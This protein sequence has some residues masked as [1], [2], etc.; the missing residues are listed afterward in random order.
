MK[1]IRILVLMIVFMACFGA[2][3][4]AFAA[5][6]CQ[7]VHS[8]VQHLYIEKSPLRDRI[9]SALRFQSPYR[10]SYIR[11][12]P[13]LQIKDDHML[14]LFASFRENRVSQAQQVDILL[15]HPEM[16]QMKVSKSM[17]KEFVRSYQ[18][19]LQN[20][21]FTEANRPLIQNKMT[22][23]VTDQCES[24]SCW[25]QSS[26]SLLSQLTG[27]NIS[28]AYLYACSL[29]DR[30]LR[31]ADKRTPGDLEG[32]TIAEYLYL[33]QKYGYLEE[34]DWQPESPVFSSAKKIKE[35]FEDAYVEYRNQ[36]NADPDKT[37]AQY[38]ES[39]HNIL[40]PYVADLSKA[41]NLSLG[42][43]AQRIEIFDFEIIEDSKY[44]DFTRNSYFWGESADS[45]DRKL[46]FSATGDFDTAVNQI[47]S[48]V[49]QSREVTLTIKTPKNSD[50]SSSRLL[51]KPVGKNNFREI[52]HALTV[53]GYVVDARGHLLLLKVKNSWGAKSGDQG[54][55]YLSRDYL[56]SILEG[57]S[58]LKISDEIMLNLP[59]YPFPSHSP[60]P[61]QTLP[62]H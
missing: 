51:E 45:R 41:A 40:S 46:V 29:L 49:D 16:I 15:S 12:L 42:W 39:I 3:R 50:L 13:V 28:E 24:G 8:A 32:G 10:S 1:P 14:A 56:K 22:K 53:V 60:I 37:K 2:R 62:V 26:T 31:A 48:Q 20:D 27:K 25:I 33:I 35:K 43:I 9:L 55:L 19:R 36:P 47:L 18:D 61:L 17:M 38:I 34:K 4:S 59:E 6:S 21:V 57:F 52:P 58:Y 11:N 54:F 5:F 30:G 44:R 7:T 23:A